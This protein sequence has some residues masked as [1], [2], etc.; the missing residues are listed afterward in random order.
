MADGVTRESIKP[1]LEL[2]RIDSTTDRLNAR[3]A[4]LPEQHER[5]ALVAERAQAQ[6]VLGERE[7]VLNE[8][9][10]D[11]TRLEGEIEQIDTRNEHER[12]RLYSGEVQNPRELSNIQ[13]EL[14]ALS[15]RKAHLEDQ[16]LEVMERREELDKE[17]GE[18][19]TSM[20]ALDARI[21]DA[22]TRR[23]TATLEIDKELSSLSSERAGIV[24]G[25]ERE[26]LDLYEDLRAKYR[27]VAVG[28]LDDGTCR[29]CGLPLSPVALDQFK[30]SDEPFVRCE[31]CRRLL[32][33]R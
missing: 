3:R 25:L 9:V 13:A 17:V 26:V 21:A 14:D 29:A 15:R 33:A 19:R 16:E 11:Q 24:P 30:R 18:L 23:D 32:I 5:D 22:T 28:A 10:H 4:D 7:T 1:L 12:K 31:N 6:G 20:T 8:L 2:Q 27:G